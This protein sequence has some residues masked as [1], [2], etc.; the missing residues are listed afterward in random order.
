[1]AGTTSTIPVVIGN[2]VIQIPNT[3]ASAIW[4]EAIIQFVQAVEVQLQ[5]IASPFDI[6]PTVQVLTSNTNAAINLTGTGAN[7]TFPS[8]SVR[9]FVFTYSIYRLS[10]T[11]SV[12]ETGTV[13]GVYN[14]D[15]ASWSMQH[16]YI[17]DVQTS[18]ASYVTF[19]MSGSDELLLTTVAIP[20]VYDSTDSKISYSA[21][22]ELVE[23]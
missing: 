17:G 6:P 8:G 15:D 14:T 12:T 13:I 22:T 2:T 4:S 1:M 11:D 21:Q 20:G 7:L 9:S 19:S 18:G 23:T 10:S 5:A 3:G 16:E